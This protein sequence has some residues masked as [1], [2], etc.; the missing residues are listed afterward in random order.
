MRGPERG[1]MGV[2]GEMGR[3][4]VKAETQNGCLFF[5]PIKKPADPWVG[6]GFRE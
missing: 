3:F 2:A 1:E 6:G 5:K 4:L